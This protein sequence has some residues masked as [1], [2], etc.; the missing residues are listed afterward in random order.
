MIGKLFINGYDAWETWGVFL[1]DG[2]YDRLLS[3]E[4]MKPYTTNQSRSID[5]VKV[6]IKN[7]RVEEKNVTLVFCFS[8]RPVSFLTRL[9]TFLGTLRNGKL[10][11]GKIHPTEL[12][13]PDLGKTFRLIYEGNGTLSQSGLKIGKIM[14]RFTEPNPTNRL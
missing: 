3:G 10:V 7:P 2:S 4:T 13:V 1:E 11:D 14:V 9:E 6:S 8:E 5:G 12:N